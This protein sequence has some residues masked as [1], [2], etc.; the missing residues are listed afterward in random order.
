M[1]SRVSD[2]AFAD[3]QADYARHDG[4]RLR[5]KEQLHY[6][7]MFREIF[8]PVSAVSAATGDCPYC[9]TVID[10]PRRNYC[11]V[12]GAWGFDAA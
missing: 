9:G 5:E 2:E 8:G 1:A 3:A 12:C 11:G 4:V 10:P 7:R 6:Y